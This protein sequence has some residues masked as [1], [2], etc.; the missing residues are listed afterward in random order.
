MSKKEITYSSM[1]RWI[2]KKTAAGT[3][4]EDLKA[5][6]ASYEAVKN[7]LKELAARVAV[8]RDARKAAR[9]ALDAA[10]RQARAAVKKA[11]AEAEKAAKAAKKA[12][13]RK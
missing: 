4:P 8:K 6:V 10:F 11:E 13:S 3:V 5:A 1:Q 12:E 2:E 7:D 9:E